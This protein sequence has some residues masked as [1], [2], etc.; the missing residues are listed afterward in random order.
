MRLRVSGSASSS[1]SAQRS[2]TM[3]A[4]SG[5][6]LDTPPKS[7]LVS[8]NSERT[9]VSLQIVL[10]EKSAHHRQLLMLA[11]RRPERQRRP[12]LRERGPWTARAPSAS[13]RPQPA[14][15][16]EFS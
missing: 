7:A 12:S 5:G 4:N 10:R 1:S 2:V 15:P 3:G 9:G 14:A 13:A 6:G 11:Q 16:R 8:A